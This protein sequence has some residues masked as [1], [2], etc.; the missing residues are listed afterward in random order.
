MVLPPVLRGEILAVKGL[1]VGLTV[2]VWMLV[3][4]AGYLGFQV[5]PRALN[6]AGLLA[7]VIMLTASLLVWAGVR[8]VDTSSLLH[9]TPNIAQRVRG[10]RFEASSLGGGALV[11]LVLC[12]LRSNRRRVLV[13]IAVLTGL[14][15]WLT[16]SR[17]T[18][19]VASGIILVCLVAVLAPARPLHGAARYSIVG[20]ATVLVTM[21]LSFG[22]VALLRQPLWADLRAAT[23]DASR[24]IWALASLSSLVKYPF[25]QGLAGT[26]A[27]T[28]PLLLDAAENVRGI[29]PASDFSEV[30]ALALG[31]TDQAL[32][33]KTIPALAATYFGIPGLLAAASLYYV[34]GQR[35][36]ARLNVPQVRTYAVGAVCFALVS[37]SY[38]GGLYS[39]EQPLLCGAL[40]AA[41]R[42]AEGGPR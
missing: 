38:F 24:S 36:V 34:L 30:R 11:G 21:L 28:P 26:L 17:G 8:F 7:V 27:W 6:K 2:V 33:P 23:S 15:I 35:L 14:I 37:S 42:D 19:V 25:G 20:A 29:F 40:L 13:L 39:W 4:Q 5:A 22:L 31:R 1:K 10:T 32:S 9:A 18:L 41:A 16:A 3:L 12:S